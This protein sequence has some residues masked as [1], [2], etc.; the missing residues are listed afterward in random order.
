MSRPV[1]H[2]LAPWGSRTRRPTPACRPE[3][4]TYTT[5]HPSP[6]VIR[7]NERNRRPLSSSTSMAVGPRS[8]HSRR[9]RTLRFDR[10]SPTRM[11]TREEETYGEDRTSS[12]VGNAE[13][14]EIPPE[15]TDGGQRDEHSRI[16]SNRAR[17]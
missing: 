6:R 2:R 11:P 15:A 12:G 10:D 17:T 9:G 7:E 14:S 4:L 5:S 3:T 16:V 1:G 8:G 13:R